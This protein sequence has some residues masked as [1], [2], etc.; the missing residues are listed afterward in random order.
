MNEI[1]KTTGLGRVFLTGLL[2]APLWVW[3]IVAWLSFAWVVDWGTPYDNTDDQENEI[4]SGM[5]LHTD[6]LTGCQYLKAGSLGGITPRLDGD[7]KH[8]GCR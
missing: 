2:S 3:L 4:R 7:G 5:I 8:V 1:K 6:N